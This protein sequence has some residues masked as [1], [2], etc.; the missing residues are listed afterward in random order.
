MLEKLRRELS[1]FNTADLLKK[2]GALHLDPRNASR[3]FSLD[4]LAHLVSAQEFRPTAPVIS[5]IRFKNLMRDCLG[6]HSRPGSF[7]DPFPQL[8]IEEILFHQGPYMVFPG[9]TAGDQDILRWLLRAAD[10][11]CSS[12]QP[13]SFSGEMRAA[14][15]LCLSVSND[16]ACKAGLK[17]GQQPQGD[18]GDDIAVPDARGFEQG[19]AAVAFSL[20]EIA[21]I[22]PEDVVPLPQT[23]V[24]LCT[25]P[26]THDWVSYSSKW[27]WLHYKPFV[28]MGDNL[29]VPNPSLFVTALRQRILYLA[30]EHNMMEDLV[31]QFCAV[32]WADIKD[33]LG[34]LGSRSIAFPL[35]KPLPTHCQEGVFSLDTDKLLYVQLV[36]DDLHDFTGTFDPKQ[37]GTNPTEVRIGE[38]TAYAV[39][40]LKSRAPLCE[41]V[42]VLTIIQDVGR[43]IDV[44]WGQVPVDSLG[45][46]MNASDLRSIALDSQDPLEL[47]KYARSRQRIWETT[48]IVGTD[49]LDEYALYRSLE[50]SFYATDERPNLLVASGFGPEF[51]RRVSQKR[52][53]HI[54]PSIRMGRLTE[55]WALHDASIP[56]SVPVDPSGSQ[57]A[58]VVEGDLPMPVWVVGPEHTEEGLEDITRNLIELVAHWLW[59]FQSHLAPILAHLT[60]HRGTYVIRLELSNPMQW[61]QE[62]TRDGPTQPNA[63]DLLLSHTRYAT[64]VEISVHPGLY[65]LLQGPDNRGERQLFGELF[66]I[67]REASSPDTQS[68]TTF[69]EADIQAAIDSVIP[70]GPK[71]KIIV[72]PLDSDFDLEVERLPRLRLV[73]E[74][75]FEEIRD[76]TGR[77]LQAKG[78]SAGVLE[79]VEDRCA[80]LNEAVKYCVSEL[81]KLIAA[82]N[83]TELLPALIA[84]QET[85]VR[86]NRIRPF[87]DPVRLAWSE[88]QEALLETLVAKNDAQ[89]KA[90]TANRFL[91]EYSAAQ[92][93][94][95]T[96]PF[97]L[98]VYDRLLAL[99][100]EIV[101][102]GRLSDLIQY[103][104]THVAIEIL[105]SGR[106]GFDEETSKKSLDA[107]MSVHMK[108]FVREEQSTFASQWHNGKQG[109]D[110]SDSLVAAL[111]KVF[112]DEFG[113]TFSQ[114]RQLLKCVYEL[115]DMQAG[116]VKRLRQDE[117][118]LALCQSL[119][120][121]RV[122]VQALIK[123]MSLVP[124]TSFWNPK[125]AHKTDVYPWKFNRSL[126]FLRRPIV[127]ITIDDEPWLTWGN[128]Y[129]VQAIA[130]LID[131][132][133]TGRFRAKSQGL[134]QWI[135]QR[136]QREAKVFEE[137]VGQR[138]AAISGVCPQVGVKKVGRKRIQANGNDLGD[139]DVLGIVPKARIVLAIECKDFSFART[140]SEMQNQM[141]ELV[142]GTHNKKAVATKHLARVQW[143]EDNL[144]EVLQQFKLKKKGGWKVKPVLVSDSELYALYL[145]R[146]AFPFWSM[147][148]LGKM[149]QR[150]ILKK[151]H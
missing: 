112:P 53:I 2:T 113:L 96:K 55:V 107:Y 139:I 79:S 24:P 141:V 63:S 78:R 16:I 146:L 45:L 94:H 151:L 43:E 110:S 40:H 68:M 85:H 46:T 54:V 130:Y 49:S 129:L 122:W 44:E 142:N 27:R 15:A 100:H 10:L 92:P 41:R 32:V 136:K 80:V 82:L 76:G 51:R 17:R 126:S 117:M 3:A 103:G 30:L 4:A 87:A 89:G 137:K 123:K 21:Q 75:E 36:T 106:L 74:S 83:A 66:R 19:G 144:D 97:S 71:K 104:L 12:G 9:P 65:A 131:L 111:D 91:I 13:G 37:T 132:Y 70:L 14:A 109:R 35:P 119:G 60:N 93:P 105:P 67:F 114:L 145:K 95:G 84:H 148:T 133:L 127:Q 31:E 134:K 11:L 140:P 72:L 120:W 121:E 90:S 138:I 147:E 38:R 7:D 64:E 48:K 125:D 56:I 47:W 118:E 52:D 81:E 77:Y 149:T 128:R 39:S 102:W 28:K 99:A 23:L 150:D 69:A 26:G 18:R 135:G 58:L 61:A 86:E 22:V 73:Q 98:E 20:P 62:I 88:N 116:P 57:K 8:F 108:G 124:R 33:S 50:R 29:L 34:F 101:N 25:E 6:G 1:P 42:L 59:Q 5:Q 143:L 115:G